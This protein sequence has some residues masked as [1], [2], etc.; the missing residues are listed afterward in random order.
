MTTPQKKSAL[1]AGTDQGAEVTSLQADIKFCSGFGQ[2][3]T[4]K[5][6][7]KNRNPYLT[8]TMAELEAMVQDPQSVAKENAQWMLASALPSRVFKEQEQNGQFWALWADFDQDPKPIA[9][10]AAWWKKQTGAYALLY[11]SRSAT[12]ERQKSRLIVPLAKPLSGAD[13][14]L[15]Q[16]CLNDALEAAGFMP[17]RVSERAAQLCYLPNRGE[18]YE[19]RILD[20]GRYFDPLTFFADQIAA[21]K[22]AIVLDEQEAKKRL[23]AAEANRMAF[24]TS[25]STSAIDAFNSCHTVDEVLLKAGYTRK[26]SHYRHPQS[27]S[28]GYSASVKDGRVFSLSSNDPLFTGG[29][30]NGAHDAFSAWTVLFFGGD[31]TA[32]AKVVYGQMR[33][34]A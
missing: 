5:A 31:A 25:G 26:G 16:E 1:T 14:L 27:E 9:V 22:A 11:S 21:K 4:N 28:G 10:I 20:D 24:R 2:L 30:G 3:H 8:L 12:V 34:A 32:A 15:A 6:T 18:F 33:R 13:W 17:D 7:A 19:Y 23:K 29:A